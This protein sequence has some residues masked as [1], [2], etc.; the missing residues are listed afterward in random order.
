MKMSNSRARRIVNEWLAGQGK[1]L[2]WAEHSYI[3]FVTEVRHLTGIDS[4]EGVFDVWERIDACAWL[5]VLARRIEDKEPIGTTLIA[6]EKV[7]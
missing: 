7:H 4:L 3:D 1:Q 6:M 5:R 2:P